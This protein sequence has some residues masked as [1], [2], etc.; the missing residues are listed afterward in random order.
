MATGKKL[1]ARTSKI[2]ISVWTPIWSKLEK[3][4]QSACLK[5]DAYIAALLDR[6]LAE[7][8]QEL[9]IGNSEEARQFIGRQLRALLESNYTP[10]SIAVPAQTATKLEA[11]CRD[12]RIVRD[13]F[14]NRL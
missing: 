13:A 7:L 10:L 5:R 14:F 1:E 11:I 4:L 3:T 2:T 9:P 8:E 6:E 12:R